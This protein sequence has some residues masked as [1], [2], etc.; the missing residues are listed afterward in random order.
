MDAEFQR[1]PDEPPKSN[2]LL[3]WITII[4]VLFVIWWML[5]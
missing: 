1:D 3:R 4:G 2:W 5:A